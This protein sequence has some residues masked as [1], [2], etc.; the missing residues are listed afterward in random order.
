MEAIGTGGT[1]FTFQQVA[2]L[3]REDRYHY[4]SH[5]ESRMA[6]WGITDAQVKAAVMGETFW[7]RIP[8]T[9]AG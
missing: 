4:S 9:L 6:E 2:Q 7:R 3:V 5:A 8:T 1:G